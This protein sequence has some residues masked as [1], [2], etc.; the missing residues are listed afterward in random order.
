[1]TNSFSP[2]IFVEISDF[3]LLVIFVLI[4]HKVY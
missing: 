4:I 2:V 1:M 3:I